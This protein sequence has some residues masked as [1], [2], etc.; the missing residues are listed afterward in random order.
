MKQA[1]IQL[2]THLRHLA[3]STGL[4]GAFLLVGTACLAIGS[5]YVHPAGPWLVVGIVGVLLG[6]ALAVPSRRSR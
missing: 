5:A 1:V 4:E 6:L 3:A 2:Q